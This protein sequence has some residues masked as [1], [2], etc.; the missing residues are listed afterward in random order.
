MPSY[1]RRSNSEPLQSPNWS[2]PD[3]TTLRSH[4]VQ[5]QPMSLPDQVELESELGLDLSGVQ[6]ML[7]N[8][9]GM[10]NMGADAAATGNQ[11]YFSNSNP[12]YAQQREE[13]IHLLQQSRAQGQGISNPNSTTERDASR[14]SSVGTTGSDASVHRDETNTVGQQAV[15]LQIN[16][17]HEYVITKSDYD[18]NESECIRKVARAH[19]MMPLNLMS[20]NQHIASLATAPELARYATIP[21]LSVGAVLYIPSS[22]ELAFYECVKVSD[23]VEAAQARYAKL[24][25]SSDLAILRA[26]RHRA[27][28][29]IGVG[30]GNKGL[31][32]EVAGPFLTPNPVLA[33]ASSRR[34][35]EIGGRLEYRVNWNATAAGFWKC[36]VFLHDVVYQAGF[37]P[38]VQSNNHYLLAGRLQESSNMEEVSVQD[39]APGCLWQRF[40]GTG[41]DESHNAILTSFVTVESDGDEYDKWRFTILGAE[42]DSAGE[43]ERIH[44]MNKGTNENTSGKK[45]RFFRPKFKRNS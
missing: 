37:K 35:E 39:A 23:T 31:G 3:R 10:A 43:S 16:E 7:G 14:G 32:D 13:V 34:S 6:A 44:T 29:Q 30:Y 19:G 27:S 22:D 21:N 40:G 25:D 5:G 4:G 38:H 45:V 42:Q 12:S 36:S 17:G 11:V 2:T 28:G 9:D 33:G 20:F 41:S 24:M 26:A 18:V 1:Q 8:A 15:N